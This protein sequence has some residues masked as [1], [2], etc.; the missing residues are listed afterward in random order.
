MVVE[1]PTDGGN[2]IIR[3]HE[4]LTQDF[5]PRSDLVIFITS[6]DRPFTESERTFMQRIREW[7]KKVVILLNKTDLLEDAE[8]DGQTEFGIQLSLDFESP[9][10]LAIDV[11]SSTGDS[12]ID[13][14]SFSSTRPLTRPPCR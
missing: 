11:L 7:G 6:A 5:V 13:V 3:Q 8:V 1:N 12:M 2:A 9:V 4:Q 10:A 14:S